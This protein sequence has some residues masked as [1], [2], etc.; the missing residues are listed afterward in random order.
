MSTSNRESARRR[1]AFSRIAWWFFYLLLAIQLI[2]LL[3]QID[4]DVDNRLTWGR[5]LIPVYVMI[6]LYTLGTWMLEY[7]L[8]SYRR[9]VEWNEVCGTFIV[10]IASI[11]RQGLLIAGVVLFTLRA[12]RVGSYSYALPFGLLLGWVGLEFTRQTLATCCGNGGG[13]GGNGT[14][15]E[16]IV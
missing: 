1:L 6:G 14:R 12:D 10:G 15:M 13:D 5:V 16:V 7:S 2:L 9:M 8:M 11:I 4:R 3:V